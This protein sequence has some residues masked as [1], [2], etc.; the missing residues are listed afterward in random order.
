MLC[1]RVKE[2]GLLEQTRNIEIALLTSEAVEVRHHFVHA[3]V[4]GAEHELALVVADALEVGLHPSR[5][6][7]GGLERLLVAGVDVHVDQASHD[8]VQRVEGRPH[9]FARPLLRPDG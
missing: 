3:A 2:A 8:L 9:I 6:A 7:L 4:F 5:H 1:E